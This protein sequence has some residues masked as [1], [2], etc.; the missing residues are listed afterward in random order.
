MVELFCDA[1]GLPRPG[2][3]DDVGVSRVMR[4]RSLVIMGTATRVRR[5][6]RDLTRTLAMAQHKGTVDRLKAGDVDQVLYARLAHR[7]QLQEKHPSP[8]AGLGVSLEVEG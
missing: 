8:R 1:P 2:A 7:R 6:A 5:V 3:V 4:R